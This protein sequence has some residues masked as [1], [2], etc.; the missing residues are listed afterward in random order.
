MA[1]IAE[2]IKSLELRLDK[3]ETIIREREKPS[4][5]KIPMTTSRDMST[6]KSIERMRNKRHDTKTNAFFED[7]VNP[8]GSDDVSLKDKRN[9]VWDST[10]HCWKFYAV[11][12][13]DE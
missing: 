10:N 12:Y 7:G 4:S 1:T 8:D 6:D 3:I 11:Y 5:A 2:A 13:S 9:C